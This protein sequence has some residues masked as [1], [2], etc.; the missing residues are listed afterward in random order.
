M[1]FYFRADLDPHLIFEREVQECIWE[2]IIQSS[3]YDY[4][5]RYDRVGLQRK[6]GNGNAGKSFSRLDLRGLRYAELSS[7]RYRLGL[8]R[9][10]LP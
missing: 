2:K 1:S 10:G 9:L 7:Y 5:D 8:D 4:L 3:Y 6:K